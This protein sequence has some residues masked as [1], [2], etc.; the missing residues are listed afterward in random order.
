SSPRSGRSGADD[1]ATPAT[2]RPGLALSATLAVQTLASLVLC[3][4]A[5][6]AP[7]VA[8]TL[9]YTADRVGLLVGLMYFMAMLSGLWGGQ[10]VARLGAVR[11]SQA[12]MLACALGVLAMLGASGIALLVGAVAI[13]AGYGVVNPASTALLGRHAP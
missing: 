1:V 9:G 13:G 3:A 12:S 6:L 11:L 7:A 5:V 10:G 2:R 4:P 8:P